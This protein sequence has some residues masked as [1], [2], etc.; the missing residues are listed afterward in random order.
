M[1]RT[2]WLQLNGQTTDSLASEARRS[3]NLAQHLNPSSLLNSCVPQS[4]HRETKVSGDHETEFVISR[5]AQMLKLLETN[6]T[7]VIK[8]SVL[9]EGVAV[10]FRPTMTPFIPRSLLISEIEPHA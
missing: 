1:A 10:L 8:Q 2:R 9:K 5:G 6:T 3:K 4:E 7:S